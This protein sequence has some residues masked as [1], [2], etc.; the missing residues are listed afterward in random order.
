MLLCGCGRYDGTEIHEAVLCLLALDRRGARAVCLAPS[1]GSAEAVDHGTGQVV[2]ADSRSVLAESARL[3]RGRVVPLCEARHA[4]LSALIVP[5][6]QGVVRVL[7]EGV[8]V[9][10]ARRRA[11][12]EVE[13]FVRGFV[14]AGKPV[15]TTSLASTLL[16]TILDLPLEEDPFAVPP[17]EIRV[18]EDRRLV[19]APG[20]LTGDRIGEVAAGIERMV[21]AVLARTAPG[22]EAG[23]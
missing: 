8:A 9:A 10:G 4:A 6:G 15:G 17:A 11:I 7:M 12:P 13:A 21:E 5:G 16:A 1:G 14:D 22:P 3:G 2:E 18:D 19:W 20:Y 23:A